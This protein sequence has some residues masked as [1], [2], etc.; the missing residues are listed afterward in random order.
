MISQVQMSF[1]LS[2]ETIDQ[3]TEVNFRATNPWQEMRG[4]LFH[5]RQ[6][7]F[8]MSQNDSRELAEPFCVN[9]SHLLYTNKGK[10]KNWSNNIFE[11]WEYEHNFV[12]NK[13]KPFLNYNMLNYSFYFEPKI[14]NSYQLRL[15]S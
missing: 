1:D 3:S 13:V 9:I 2:Q 14:Q 7:N 15:R 12:N 4:T 8:L 10:W 5:K 6:N 11:R